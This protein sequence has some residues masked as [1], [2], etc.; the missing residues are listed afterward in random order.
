[1]KTECKLLLMSTVLW[2][3]ISTCIHIIHIALPLHTEHLEIN[4]AEGEEDDICETA[5]DIVQQ[6][7]CHNPDERL[8]SSIRGGGQIG[9]GG[10]DA[11]SFSCGFTYLLS[12]LH[13]F[14]LVSFPL[15]LPLLPLPL[16]PLSFLFPPPSPLLLL[17]I[18]LPP[19]LPLPFLL[20]RSSGQWTQSCFPCW[21]CEGL[22]TARGGCGETTPPSCMPLRSHSQNNT[23]LG[24]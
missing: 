11:V 5:K 14:P 15:F 20:S 3:C 1:M 16:T 12:F 23:R 7:L 10:R 19:L 6:F 13:L 22:L 17:F 2:Y 24:G 8:G 18:C 21:S 9:D 4:W